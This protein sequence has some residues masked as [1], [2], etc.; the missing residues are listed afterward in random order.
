MKAQTE[1]DRCLQLVIYNLI[2]ILFLASGMAI[3]MHLRLF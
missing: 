2:S 1:K 3:A